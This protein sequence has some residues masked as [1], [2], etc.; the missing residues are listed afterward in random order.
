MFR[1]VVRSALFLSC[2]LLVEQHTKLFSAGPIVATPNKIS[3]AILMALAIAQAV[4]APR[5]FPRSAKNACI[6][7]LA[8]SSGLSIPTA[9]FAC[10]PFGVLAPAIGQY[11]TAMIFYFSLAYLVRDQ[12]DLAFVL[13]G[14]V[15]GAALISWTSILGIGWVIESSAWG[16]RSGGLG[17]NPGRL[18]YFSMV[19]L[20]V[21]LMLFLSSRRIVSKGVVAGAIALIFVGVFAAKSR[22]SLVVMLV[23]SAFWM[24][25][26]RRFDVLRYAPVAIVL[27]GAFYWMMPQGFADRMSTMSS[28][29]SLQQDSS[30]QGRLADYTHALQALASSPITGIGF[31]RFGPWVNK[32]IDWRIPAGHNVHS[33]YFRIAAEHGLVGLIPYLMILVISFRDYSYVRRRALQMQTPND[34]ELRSLAQTAL[35][36]QVAFVG[37]LVG[38]LT[39]PTFH[40]KAAWLLYATAT[41][42]RS[43]MD[44]RL[45]APGASSGAA[46]AAEPLPAAGVAS[47]GRSGEPPSGPRAAQVT[48]RRVEE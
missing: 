25:R 18:V 5:R 34:P 37:T 12:R 43:I 10:T 14:L 41:A 31:Y 35:F 20:P 21:A 24:I 19:A 29:Q 4:V 16:F 30:W 40:F 23:M 7:V 44:A 46:V 3:V 32:E 11:A 8:V 48:W 26:L 27:A 28:A 17:G 47:E 38:N 13:W 33:S 1:V 36:L 6:V 2:A 42:M 39:Q 22:S 15:V 9:V 45:R